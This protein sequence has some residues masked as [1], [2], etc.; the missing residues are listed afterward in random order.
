[1]NIFLWILQ[2]MLAIHTAIGAVWKFSNSAQTVTGLKTIPHAV[3]LGLS[4]I[5]IAASAMLILPAL[6]ARASLAAPIAALIIAAEMIGFC[7]MFLLSGDANQNH[8][9]YWIIVAAISGFV[10]Y[11]RFFLH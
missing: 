9:V 6:S 10:A 4:V 5:E 1:M 2:A 11:A 8:L 7:V 3:W